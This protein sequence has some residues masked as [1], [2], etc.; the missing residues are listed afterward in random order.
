MAIEIRRRELG[1]GGAEKDGASNQG[2]TYGGSPFCPRKTR[3]RTW[4]CPWCRILSS[5]FPQA[6][7]VLPVGIPV[8]G[9]RDEP[10]QL[11]NPK[12]IS[13][14]F[15]EVGMLD[16][17]CFAVSGDGTGE[18]LVIQMDSHGS[19]FLVPMAGEVTVYQ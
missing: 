18:Q 4:Q 5:P 10:T 14:R 3:T 16:Q 7:S 9:G 17:K 19:G 12:L 15:R 1:R 8:V 2:H 11:F 13:L 6:S